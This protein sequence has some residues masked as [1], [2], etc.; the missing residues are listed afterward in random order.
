MNCQS[1]KKENVCLFFGGKVG[2]KKSEDGGRV[3]FDN[4]E[5]RVRD[6][7]RGSCTLSNRLSNN[8]YYSGIC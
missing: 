1:Y 8:K 7:L 3:G 5:S 2:M 6:C 4:K